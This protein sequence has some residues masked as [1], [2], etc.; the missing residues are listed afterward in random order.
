MHYKKQQPGKRDGSM[1]NI[2]NCCAVVC[3]CIVIYLSSCI[4]FGRTMKPPNVSECTKLEIRYH[5]SGQK[6]FVNCDDILNEEEIEYLD[7]F[8][9]IDITDAALIKEFNKVIQQSLYEGKQTGVYS[10]YNPVTIIGFKNEKKVVSF[11][12]MRSLIIYEGHEFRCKPRLLNLRM[13]YPPEVRPYV[14]RTKCASNMMRLKTDGFW[15]LEEQYV[16]PD[17]WCDIVFQKMQDRTI[18]DLDK[19]VRYRSYTDEQIAGY[20]LCPTVNMGSANPPKPDAD[21]EKLPESNTSETEFISSYALNPNC[22]PNS[23]DDTVLLFESKPG[24]NRHGGPELFCFDNH[25]PRG[26]CVLFKNGSV[27]FIRTEAELHKLRWE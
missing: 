22:K 27:K 19:G 15:L 18:H 3:F 26:G 12:V 23:P 1:N 10:F 7:S 5:P 17:Q 24:W 14:A 16:Q 20:F 2:N 25:E 9:R 4:S 11:T 8:T 21:S 13:L 6:Y